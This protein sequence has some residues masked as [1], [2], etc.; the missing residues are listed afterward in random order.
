MKKGVKCSFT[1]EELAEI[2]GGYWYTEQDNEDSQTPFFL[3]NYF[4][5]GTGLIESPNTCFVAMSKETWLK[6]TGNTGHYRNIFSDSHDALFRN[7]PKLKDNSKLVGIIAERPIVELCGILPQLIV[8]NPY[9]AIKMLAAAA[10]KKMADNG[11][12]IAV[13]GAVGKSTT[14]NM[15]HCLLRDEAD[16]ISNIN[17]H[18]SRTGVQLWLASVGRYDPRSGQPGDKPNVC[19]LE[20]A[21]SALWMRSGGV[22]NTVRPHIGIITHIE[23]TQYQQGSRNIHEVA[24]A[25]SKI[26]QGIVPGG[27]AV[28]FRAMP[29]FDFIKE[30]V[31]GYG[32]VPVTYG[33]TPDCDSYVR[34]YEFTTPTAGQDIEELFTDIEAI[35]LGE[36]ISYRIGAIGKP[37]VL[38]SLAALTAAKLAGFDIQKIA[39]TLAGFKGNKNTM[40]LSNCGGVCILDCS[41]NLEIPSIIAAFDLLK[42]IKQ[43]PGSRKIVL[44]SRI[45]NM[46]EMAPE[47][48]LQLT[49][50]IIESGFD[51][52]FFHEP[53]DEFKYLINEIPDKN[54]GGRHHTAEE[55][56]K[57][58][59]DY[60]RAGDSILVMGAPRGCDFDKVL[61]ML[62]AGILAKEAGESQS[63]DLLFETLQLDTLAKPPAG[64]VYS[65]DSQKRLLESGDLSTTVNEGVGHILILHLV[66]S[67]LCQR[68]VSLTDQV[69]M[70]ELAWRERNQPNA[71]SV[72][73]GDSLSLKTL[74]DAYVTANAPDAIIALAHFISQTAN[75][76]SA[77][78]FKQI[79]AQLSMD[80]KVAINLT[81]RKNTR[82]EQC[83]T[84]NDLE[85]IAGWFFSLPLDALKPLNCT[86]AI[87]Q[88]KTLISNSILHSAAKVISYY[89]FGESTYN[90]IVYARVR[91]ENLAVCVCGARDAYAR[92]TTVCNMLQTLGN[93]E[94]EDAKAEWI[95]LDDTRGFS[96]L[97]IAGDTYFGEWYTRIRS[98][99]GQDDALQ[100]YGYSYSF[101]KLAPFLQEKDYN[102][103]NFEA[104]LTQHRQSPYSAFYTF[105]LDASP[106]ETLDELKRRNINAVMLAN[107]HSLDF[108]EFAGKQSKKWFI[109]NGFETIGFGETVQEAEKPL[110]FNGAGRRIIL[111]NAYWYREKRHYISRHYAMGNNAGTA[112]IA[113]SLLR[114]ITGYKEKYPDAFIIFSPHWG[115]DFSDPH[116]LQR[117]IARR[118]IDAGADCIIGHGAHIVS[119]YERIGGKFVIYSIGNFV[120]NSNGVDFIN[121]NKP[122]IGYV[123]KLFISKEYIRLRLYP[124][125]TYNPTTFWQPYPL[126]AEQ[127]KE[128]LGHNLNTQEAISRDEMGRY[129]EFI[130]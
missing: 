49:K 125:L 75:T 110:C 43:T 11:T 19:T 72:S 88:N 94:N 109:E 54:S 120:F 48:H 37:V 99:K 22:C 83:F 56:V 46:R 44:L 126:T 108:G 41:H 73:A 116:V 82:Y 20:V 25:K 58:V 121:K 21:A 71:L 27:K 4:V 129:L 51:K 32:A 84:V 111:F 107:N 112:C 85:K 59:L 91:D 55:V 40:Q 124:I 10:R 105:L 96:C 87:H 66:L 14:V 8:E 68:K 38:N 81:G 130:L 100:K 12:I 89:C 15:L 29:E 74:L 28:L 104:V 76:H 62:T 1:S 47:F 23:L 119:D 45:V 33:E 5:T 106:Q 123:S 13:T 90:A 70:G 113:D 63:P 65:L 9:A 86:A 17:G 98:A 50:P 101:E 127:F 39:H 103:V 35:V 102:M 24:I 95:A 114:K 26:C 30:T 18:N 78:Y 60:I 128:Y 67:L 79:C 80:D 36:K 64:I 6:G 118:A 92:D 52:F 117:Q 57:A 16:Y 122:P 7:Y 97:T 77:P 53:L 61:G 115:T 93:T 42:Q 2:L 31:T 69:P 34:K 3:V